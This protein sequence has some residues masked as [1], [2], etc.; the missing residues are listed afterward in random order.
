MRARPGD[1]EDARASGVLVVPA[2]G[3]GSLMQAVPPL[4]ISD[5]ELDEAFERLA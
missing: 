1:W 2:G 4:T 5:A 3:D